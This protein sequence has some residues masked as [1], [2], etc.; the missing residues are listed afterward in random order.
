[1]MKNL[2]ISL[3]ILLQ[4]CSW[5]NMKLGLPDDNEG[6][7][8]IEAAIDAKTDL[9]IDLTPL[10]PEYRTKTLSPAPPMPPFIPGV[11]YAP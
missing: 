11:P 9:D 4:S 8:L 3:L 1:M 5:I 6:E 7:E 10:T 2:T